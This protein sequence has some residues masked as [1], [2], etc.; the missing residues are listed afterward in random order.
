MPKLHFT[1]RSIDA[2][3][4]PNS[5]QILYRDPALRGFGVRV[6][7]QSKV[8][9]VEGQVNHRTKRVSIG[10]A[11]VLSV[12]IARKRALGILSE[13]SE[14]KDP[15]AEKRREA[16]ESLT[17]RNAFELFFK[18]RSTLVPSTVSSYRL[19]LETYLQGWTNQ[20]L[21]SITRQMV[22]KRHQA[23]GAERGQVTANNAM[24]HFRSVYNFTAA[25]QDDFPPNPVM[26][27]TQARA[28]FPERRRRGVV[29]AQDLPVWW[30]AVLKEP[31]YSR[32]FLFMA[33]FTGMRRSEIASLPWEI[34]QY[35]Q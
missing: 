15:T 17:V 24:R 29:S 11:D 23:I 3:S 1:K 21:T 22:L 9:F 30:A 26:I 20:P 7:A 33:L 16:K 28:W 31:D 12:D 34:Y 27:L 8:Y 5:G 25:T 32:D 19:T 13:M 10:R 6:G 35:I 18:G 2:I 14:G 4:Y